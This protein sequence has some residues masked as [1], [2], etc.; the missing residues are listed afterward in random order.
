MD[1][2]NKPHG[3]FAIALIAFILIAATCVVLLITTLVVWLSALTGS[4]IWATLI[5]SGLCLLIAAAIYLFALRATL[6]RIH[7][8]IETI[9]EVAHAAR[10]SYDWIT[11]RL[12][13]RI[14][15]FLKLRDIWRDL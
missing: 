11:E 7:D 13:E 1:C 8:Q 6:N 9:Y 14:E 10:R 5:V 12:S 3:H 4:I 15:F 2:E